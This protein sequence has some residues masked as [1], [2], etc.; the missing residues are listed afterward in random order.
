MTEPHY[1]EAPGGWGLE[2]SLIMTLI[3]LGF[4]ATWALYITSPPNGLV[5]PYGLVVSSVTGTVLVA[6]VFIYVKTLA[7]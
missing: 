4:V 7:T 2:E 5:A 3:L 1:E 6:Y